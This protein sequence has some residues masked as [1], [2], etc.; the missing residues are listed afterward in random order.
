MPVG[1]TNLKVVG[2]THPAAPEVLVDVNT[3]NALGLLA[4]VLSE[5]R[6][7]GLEVWGALGGVPSLWT[8]ATD[9]IY[10]WVQN[11]RENHFVVDP[12][13][14]NFPRVIAACAQSAAA[15]AAE[16]N[17]TGFVFNDEAAFFKPRRADPDMLFYQQFL[18]ALADAMHAHGLKLSATIACMD[19]IGPVAVD[20]RKRMAASPV[21]SFPAMDTCY[22]D[23][24]HFE[25]RQLLRTVDEQLCQH[26]AFSRSCPWIGLGSS[27]TIC[28]RMP[29]QEECPSEGL[30]VL[31][32]VFT[33]P[34]C[35]GFLLAL[36]EWK[37]ARTCGSYS[38]TNE[39]ESGT[40]GFVKALNG[41]G[42]GKVEHSLLVREGGPQ[43]PAGVRDENCKQGERGLRDHRCGAMAGV[44]QVLRARSPAMMRPRHTVKSVTRHEAD[45]TVHA[46]CQ[47]R[48]RVQAAGQLTAS[49]AGITS[50]YRHGLCSHVEPYEYGSLA[51][52]S[53]ELLGAMPRHH[54]RTRTPFRNC[55]EPAIW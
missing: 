53:T 33:T 6:T 10:P 42:G 35:A 2:G 44:L 7:Q 32:E 47:S 23:F 49:V 55:F 27:L 5:C 3:E 18:D 30:W 34:A 41:R 28:Q 38:G 14:T 22:G 37:F 52:A 40:S 12:R 29:S 31:P 11:P 4:P 19:E 8:H 9:P 20:I 13:D 16:Y 46:V 26:S 15:V 21:D 43:Q 24:A 54:T 50:G 51:G 39:H 45:D 17:L 36:Y 1:L 48:E 25:P